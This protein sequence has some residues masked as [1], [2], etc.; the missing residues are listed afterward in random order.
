[1]IAYQ[2]YGKAGRVTRDTPRAAAQAYLDSYPSTRKCNDVQGKM[3]G[4]FFTVTYGLASDGQ[5]PTSYKDVTKK[6]AGDLPAWP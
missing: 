1:M 3:D 4:E 6:T 5:W 2:A